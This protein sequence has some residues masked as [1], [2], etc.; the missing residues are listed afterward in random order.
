MT[1]E[2]FTRK[3]WVTSKNAELGSL[4]NWSLFQFWLFSYLTMLKLVMQR[5]EVCTYCKSSLGKLS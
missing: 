1:Q 2:F 3:K 4:H 5:Q